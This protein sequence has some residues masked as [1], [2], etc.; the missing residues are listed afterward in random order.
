[1]VARNR[2]VPSA[3]GKMEE[4]LDRTGLMLKIQEEAMQKL[5]EAVED[6]RTQLVTQHN[7]VGSATAELG[8]SPPF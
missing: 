3:L 8:G 6:L 7:C 1:M 4:A 2:L 5:A